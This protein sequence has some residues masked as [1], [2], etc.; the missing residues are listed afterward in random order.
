M[1]KTKKLRDNAIE[2]IYDN[3][4][5]YINHNRVVSLKSKIG[6][7]HT[8]RIEEAATLMLKD[9]LADFCADYAETW[10]MVPLQ[11]ERITNNT[12]SKVNTFLVEWVEKNS[13]RG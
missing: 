12:K 7:I 5:R 9:I 6:E 8:D 1:I 13:K 4:E 11:H 3:L 2:T 10:D